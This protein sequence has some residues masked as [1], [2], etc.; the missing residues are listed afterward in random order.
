MSVI[1]SKKCTSYNMIDVC[2]SY[3]DFIEIS[4]QYIDQTY[5]SYKH[6]SLLKKDISL[7]E[8]FNGLKS[9][10]LHVIYMMTSIY[11]VEVSIVTP[12]LVYS[13]YNKYNTLERLLFISKQK[14]TISESTT[15]DNDVDIFRE[16]Q[17]ATSNEEVSQAEQ[18][19]IKKLITDGKVVLRITTVESLK[20]I[21]TGKF[22]NIA[23]NDDYFYF[24]GKTNLVMDK[25]TNTVDVKNLYIHQVKDSQSSPSSQSSQSSPSS[26]SSQ[27][28]PLEFMHFATIIKNHKSRLQPL[29]DAGAIIMKVTLDNFNL[30][31]KG[32]LNQDLPK[33]ILDEHFYNRSYKNIQK[34]DGKDIDLD[35]TCMRFIMAENEQL[36]DIDIS[37]N[38]LL[39]VFS[40]SNGDKLINDLIEHISDYASVVISII[41]HYLK[42]EKDAVLQI[43]SPEKIKITSPLLDKLLMFYQLLVFICNGKCT[44][45]MPNIFTKLYENGF[46]TDD[47]TSIF[48]NSDIR[49]KIRDF[50]TSTFTCPTYNGLPIS[51][52]INCPL[53]YY[54][55]TALSYDKHII[56]FNIVVFIT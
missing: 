4:R 23:N 33:Y 45:Q 12:L 27:S 11:I 20:N 22:L 41:N 19:I 47:L 35:L 56:Q 38:E 8:F 32:D 55:L 24:N 39:R 16:I 14:S 50:Y 1:I 26:Q 53:K 5:T 31:M 6:V 51:I 34:L 10:G 28:S 13:A 44:T 3:E 42:G 54:P 48:S 37:F 43:I 15:T 40:M 52:K 36:A 21:Y 49:I 9:A 18:D 2:T 7:E 17:D 25:N 46:T 30:I 29:V